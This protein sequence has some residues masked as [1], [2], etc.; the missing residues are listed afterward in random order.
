MCCTQREM[1]AEGKKIDTENIYQVEVVPCCIPKQ[2]QPSDATVKE[3][4]S[5]TGTDTGIP[6]S[7]CH[8]GTLRLIHVTYRAEQHE[9]EVLPVVLCELVCGCGQ[10]TTLVR[11]VLE[12]L[13]H[14]HGRDIHVRPQ[15]TEEDSPVKL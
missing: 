14:Q 2:K 13:A 6:C 3:R 9:G 12:E 7:T 4:K 11:E 1:A 8:I 5:G 10:H 15:E